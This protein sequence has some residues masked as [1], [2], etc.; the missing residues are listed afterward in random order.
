MHALPKSQIPGI[1]IEQCH[2]DFPYAYYDGKRC[3]RYNE[4]EQGYSLTFSSTECKNNLNA[5]CKEERCISNGK[6]RII[7]F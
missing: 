3:C 2:S 5:K 7:I 6:N 1:E 4:N